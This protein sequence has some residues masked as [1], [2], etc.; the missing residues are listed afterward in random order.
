[1]REFARS[2]IRVLAI[3][4]GLFATPMLRG[5]PQDVQDNLAATLP[6]PSRF[7]TP[8]EYAKLVL[9]MVDNP[10][11]NGEVVRLDSGIRLAPR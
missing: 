10:I 1:M 7:G 2:G 11:L 9:H 5:L 6:F 8:E 3:A 4:P